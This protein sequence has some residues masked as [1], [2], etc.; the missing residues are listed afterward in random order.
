MKF[1]LAVRSLLFVILI[2]GTVAGYI[3]WRILQAS[4]QLLVPKFSVT[5]ILAAC[6]AMMGL[7]ILLRCVWDFFAVGRGTLAPFD[8]PKHLVVRGLYRFTRNPMY[9][10]VLALLLGEA[11]LFHSTTLLEYAIIVFVIFHLMVIIYEEPA[12]ESQFGASYR[13]YRAAVPRW[14]FTTRAFTKS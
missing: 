3:P 4:G 10:G 12:L 8:A 5:T 7:S 1:F 14:G 6:V 11:W 9:N 2:P 13:A